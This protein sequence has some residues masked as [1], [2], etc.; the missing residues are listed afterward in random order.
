MIPQWKLASLLKAKKHFSSGSWWILEP[1]NMVYI[2]CVLK[3]NQICK[4][5]SDFNDLFIALNTEQR[6]AV[7]ALSL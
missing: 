4:I 3:K 5:S 6:A 7:T 1:L 2:L